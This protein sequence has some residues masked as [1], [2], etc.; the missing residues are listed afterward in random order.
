MSVFRVFR[1]APRYAAAVVGMLGLGTAF[2]VIT[3]SHIDAALFRPAPF[4]AVDRVFLAYNVVTSS[5][6]TND[7]VRWSYPALQLLRR[8]LTGTATVASYSPSLLTLSQDGDAEA[9][10]GEIASPEYFRVLGATPLRG[11]VF[12]PAEDSAPGAHPVVLLGHGLWRR[13][14]GGDSGI[15]GRTIRVNGQGLSVIGVMRPGFRGLTGTGDLW[16]PTSMAPLLTYPLY[17]TS[18]QHFISAAARLEQ[19]ISPEAAQA[20]MAAAAY[21]I[22]RSLPDEDADPADVPGV[23]GVPLN[24]ARVSETTRRSLTLL[25]GGAALLYLLTCANVVNLMLGRSV[26]R[27]REA[28]ILLAIGGSRARRVAHFAREGVLLSLA[29]GALGCVAGWLVAPLI[30]VPVDAWGPRSLYGSL[31]PFATPSPGWRMVLFGLALTCATTAG[32]SWAPVFA[33]IRPSVAGFLRDGSGISKGAESL[34][35]PSGRGL[36]MAAEA[37]L[38]VMLLVAG[39]LL[40]DSFRRMRQTDLGVDP[41]QV[42]TFWVRPPESQV[43]PE[44]AP[45]F[46]SRLLSAISAVP[47]VEAVTVDGGAPV[48]GSARST[49]FIASHPPIDPHDAP[50][51]LRHYI[52]PD[53]FR[54]LGIPLL[55]GRVFDEGDVAGRPRVAVISQSAALKFWPGRDPIGERVWFGGSAFTTRETSVEIVGVVGDVVYEPLDA[56]T[57]RADFYTPYQQFTYG[58]RNVLVRTGGDP[59]AVVPGIRAAVASVDPDLPLVDLQ[60]LPDRI[61]DSWARQRFDAA[62]FAGFALVALLLA[63]SGVYSVVSF[64]VRQRTQEMG[65]RL[66]LGAPP[67]AIVRMVVGEGMIF[68]LVGLIAGAIGAVG[69]TKVLRSSLY[70]VSPGDARVPATALVVLLFVAILAC[71]FPARRATEV[72]PARTLRAE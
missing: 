14:F 70:Q 23:I 34:Q 26:G 32:L 46:V 33:L 7:R 40:V 52:G 3:F 63:A 17:L 1:R 20:R 12:L 9:V 25:L 21:E 50:P 67:R 65:I 29:G 35:R 62:V 61:G 51:V 36:I 43:P 19:G 71:Y 6:G 24:Q 15:V 59:L 27:R 66:A 60:T 37:A 2:L 49:L 55:R 68:P 13:K 30:Q 44:K 41:D 5:R 16:I 45:A 18:P 58:S 64:A 11:R 54:V 38:A 22:S 39:G 57:N 47:G 4:P 56:G 42:L 8:Q 10:P 53:H 69:V 48:S 72:D 31:S 28:A